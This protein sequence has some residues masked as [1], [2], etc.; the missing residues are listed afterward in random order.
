MTCVVGLITDV[1]LVFGADSLVTTETGLKLTL[2]DKKVFV[3]NNVLFGFCGDLRFG[4]LVKHR[5]TP[6][7][8]GR[9][10]DLEAFMH[11]KFLPDLQKFCTDSGVLK[12][13]DLSFELLIGIHRSI[14]TI[15]SDFSVVEAST[16]YQAIGS[17]AEYALGV[18]YATKSLSNFQQRITL[19]L[20]ASSAFSQTVAKPFHFECL[21]TTPKKQVKTKST[22]RK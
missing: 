22:S 8:P 1:G 18:M 2:L 16:R 6:P 17:G 14:Y 21:T 13:E 4:Q 10:K 5:F 19:A 7:S 3:K 20:E 15:A 11:T 12:M 9:S